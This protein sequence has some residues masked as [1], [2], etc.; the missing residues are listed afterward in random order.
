VVKEERR[1][2]TEDNPRALMY[3]QQNA[4]TFV[5]SPYRRPIVGWMSDLDAMTPR[6][7]APFI[8][9]G[10]PPP[11]PPWW[12]PAMWTW[13]RCGAG[14]K[15]LR[16]HRCP[17]VPARKPRIEPVQA[18]LRRIEFKAPAEQAYVAWPSRCRSCRP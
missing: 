15:I 18:G 9:A 2:R 16:R 8:A 17:P 10:T 1:L 3:E 5:A 7:R 4:T 14:R 11:T 6:T 12:W 13:A